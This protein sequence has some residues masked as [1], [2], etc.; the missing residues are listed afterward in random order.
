M[1]FQTEKIRTLL[2]LSTRVKDP[3]SSLAP[4]SLCDLRCLL[5]KKFSTLKWTMGHILL[6]LQVFA[7]FCMSPLHAKKPAAVHPI[8]TISHQ[9]AVNRT[10]S[11]QSFFSD[12]ITVIS[13]ALPL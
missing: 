1:S 5:L 13:A 6:S 12:V 7:G 4:F 3:W 2:S 10:I 9:F 11:H 8:R